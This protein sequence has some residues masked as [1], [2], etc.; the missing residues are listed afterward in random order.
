MRVAGPILGVALVATGI[1]ALTTALLALTRDR[2]RSWVVWV[3]LAYGVL[4]VLFLLGELLLP[5]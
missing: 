5:H 4:G 3:G 1:G 2:E